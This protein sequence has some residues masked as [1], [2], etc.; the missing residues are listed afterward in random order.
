MFCFPATSGMFILLLLFVPSEM[1]LV[2]G[3]SS[4]SSPLQGNILQFV[5]STCFLFHSLA[6]PIIPSHLGYYSCCSLTLWENLH[7]YAYACGHC[8]LIILVSVRGQSG[9]ALMWSFRKFSKLNWLS[10][11]CFTLWRRLHCQAGSA[12]TGHFLSH[13]MP[14]LSLTA[15]TS[16]STVME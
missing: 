5:M 1:G 8:F 11:N 7:A 6:A 10:M 14:S 2:L 3:Q 15:R 16:H 13:Y 9:S 12:H 4:N